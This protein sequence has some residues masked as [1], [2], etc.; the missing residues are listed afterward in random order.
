MAA[1]SYTPEKLLR[2]MADVITHKYPLSDLRTI[3]KAGGEVNGAVTRGLRPLHYA[4]Y[5]NYWQAVEYLID[6]D[7]QVDVGDDIGY[8]PLHVASK[9]GHLKGK[10][11]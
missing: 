9:H 5:E 4:A 2:L 3:L 11:K 6:H 7:A 8:T 10:R 1:S